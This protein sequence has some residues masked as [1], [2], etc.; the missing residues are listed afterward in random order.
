M[1]DLVGNP[2][3]RF[4]CVSAHIWL[5]K[6]GYAHKHDLEVNILGHD[7]APFFPCCVSRNGD[8][9]LIVCLV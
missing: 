4:S 9:S 8:F 2:E 6:F 1:S 3:D 5:I 7:L